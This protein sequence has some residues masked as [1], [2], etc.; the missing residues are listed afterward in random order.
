MFLL[1][2]ISD[3]RGATND[4]ARRWHELSVVAPVMLF[5]SFLGFTFLHFMLVINIQSIV[6]GMIAGIGSVLGHLGA[7][8]ESER[9]QL[10]SL[11]LVLFSAICLPFTSKA[12][13]GIVIV[14]GLASGVG[15]FSLVLILFSIASKFL[16]E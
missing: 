4:W 15:A 3:L 8:I 13:A 10:W 16:E 2:I 11:W 5:G 14:S 9:L 1:K 12:V 6:A 7:A